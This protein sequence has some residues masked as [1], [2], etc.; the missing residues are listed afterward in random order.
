MSNQK[1]ELERIF[2]A[3]L[4]LQKSEWTTF[5]NAE[6]GNDDDLR[7]RA[8]A[9]LNAHVKSEGFLEDTVA[10]KSF[11]LADS[12]RQS[13]PSDEMHGDYIGRYRLLERLGEG[14]WGVVWMAEQTDSIKRRVA[15]KILKLGMDTREF[16]ARFESERQALA[17]MDHPNIAHVFDGGATDKGRPYF[18]MELVK[19]IRITDYCDREQLTTRDRLQL[20]IKVCQAVHHAHQKGIIHR[21]LKPSNILVA[22]TQG[23]PVPKVIDFG[24]AKATDYRL[25]EKTFFTRIQSFVG[26]PAYT[27]PEQ[28]DMSSVDVDTRSDI[29]SL[30][31][32]LY[33]ILVGRP[34]F[35][36][37]ELAEEGMENMRRKICETEPSIPSAHLTALPDMDRTVI[38]DR[39]GMET[40]KLPKLLKGDLDW[41][42]MKCLEKSRARRYDTVNG[43]ILDLERY[44][45]N[46]P[47]LASPPSKIYRWRKFVVRNRV[48]VAVSMALVMSLL[49][50]SMTI[51]FLAVQSFKA[52]EHA[53]E[54][55]QKSGEISEFIKSMFSYVDT[56]VELQLGQ[57]ANTQVI[58]DTLKETFDRASQRMG[59]VSPEARIE[60]FDIL[61]AMYFKIREYDSAENMFRRELVQLEGSA[62]LDSQKLARTMNHLGAALGRQGKLV[63]AEL[64]IREALNIQ[65]RL[66]LD[67]Q[68]IARSFV[69]LSV[70]QVKKA[71]D[72]KLPSEDRDQQ[73]LKAQQSI[74]M[75]LELQRKSLGNEHEEIAASLNE[76]GFI[77]ACQWGEKT[78][79]AENV[80]RVAL[81]MN[82]RLLGNENPAVA[83]SL[84]LLTIVQV[85]QEKFN[86][87]LRNYREVQSIRKKLI[88][89][90]T[91][92]VRSSYEVS[93]WEHQNTGEESLEA[94]HDIVEFAMFEQPPD[95]LEVARLI[96]I[97]AFT[98]LE[99]GRLEEA[100]EVARRCWEIRRK[101]S[102]DDWRCFHAESLYGAA[103]YALGRISEAEPL[104]IEG[105]QGVKSRKHQLEDHQMILLG[106]SLSRLLK[107]YLDQGNMSE[108]HRL[109]EEAK[110]FGFDL[111]QS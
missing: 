18:V 54:E 19:G 34:P 57:E 85:I 111:P 88:E 83:S 30:G 80:I 4:E 12:I 38:A 37:K 53:R 71:G 62:D 95:S 36:P 8:E 87:S 82:R 13:L 104:L 103:K 23:E 9:L 2:A 47:V 11:V 6:C 79:E 14:G 86:E 16:V 42:T 58:K 108:A 59:D 15:L 32:L 26:T 10:D 89:T 1:K 17:M 68:V 109:G 78:V 3:A 97:E 102:P 99:E 65:Q 107:F 29:Y 52:E 46:E 105:Y 7:R 21:D 81:D 69:N 63:E 39:R 93:V 75:A 66:K 56:L 45:N 110:S 92:D 74:E 67:G 24:V 70:I 106:E 5:L 84:N 33:E 50:G 96:A 22:T 76:L 28:V 27:S 20:F 64:Q 41:I 25:S 55:A 98:Y 31:V 73:L 72:A 91:K 35:D 40:E 101:L 94:L 43:L 51:S 77:L 44:L 48:A 49:V 90:N 60:L 61:G 100:E